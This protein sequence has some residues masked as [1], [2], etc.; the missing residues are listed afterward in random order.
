MSNWLENLDNLWQGPVGAGEVT[1]PAVA[2]Q[3]VQPVLRRRTKQEAPSGGFGS[4]AVEAPS[5]TFTASQAPVGRTAGPPTREIQA[6]E[7]LLGERLG[8]T[9]ADPGLRSTALTHPTWKNEHP[10]VTADNQRLEFMGDLVL[11]LAVGDL[12][13]AQLP[14]ASEGELSVLKSALVRE[15]ML[16]AVARKVG[17]GSALRL[18]RGLE[19]DGGRERV[20]L[21]AD[22]LEALLGA[23]F[24]DGGFE[25]TRAV[26]ARLFAQPLSELVTRTRS[27]G[28]EGPGLHIQT[29][30]FKSALQEKV[31]QLRGEAPS[32]Q[33]LC[34]LGRD[35]TRRFRV[36]VMT[37]VGR[38]SLRAVG[39]A[40]TMRAAEHLAAEKLLH[41]LR[42]TR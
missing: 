41:A 33:L 3:P 10:L 2:V 7:L 21:L 31:A 12:L 15:S 11:G 4:E 16:A 34:E 17:V 37:R 6:A 29:A 19:L 26:V 23:V 14:D 36:Q 24:Q 20:S 13:Q 28:V 27:E 40:G 8:H 30:N 32:Y 35:G 42:L 18:G 25:A 1:A 38:Q 9:F 5:Y 22:A 39:E